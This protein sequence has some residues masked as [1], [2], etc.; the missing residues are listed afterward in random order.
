MITPE[1]MLKIKAYMDRENMNY[2]LFISKRAYMNI[3]QNIL[4]NK[5]DKTLTEISM[6]EFVV[7]TQLQEQ[8][9]KGIIKNETRST[10]IFNTKKLEL[11]LP[12]CRKADAEKIAL[13]MRSI[14][15]EKGFNIDYFIDEFS[16]ATTHVMKV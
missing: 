14:C 9:L 10:D 8:I 16:L 13:L 6:I 11:I 3:D 7:E 1:A 5:R 12:E 15:I 4:T 2:D